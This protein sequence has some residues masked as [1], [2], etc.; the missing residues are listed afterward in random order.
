MS[1]K[2][3][4]QKNQVAADYRYKE[5]LLAK[6]INKLMWDGKKSVA[7]RI[8]YGAIDRI[9]EKKNDDGLKL[10]KQAVENVKP[11]LEVRSRRVGGANYQVPMEVRADRKVALAIRWIINSSRSRGEKTMIERLSNEMLDALENRGGAMKKREEVHR[12]AEANR[13]FAHYRW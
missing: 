6:F 2:G 11:I 1:R 13:A 8:L 7:E 9:Q 5:K 10:F 12:M 3:P 4:A